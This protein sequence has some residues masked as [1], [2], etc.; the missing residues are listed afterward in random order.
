MKKMII[1]KITSFLGD[2]KRYKDILYNIENA[3]LS[4]RT[5]S[6]IFKNADLEETNYISNK[7]NNKIKILNNVLYIQIDGA[8]ERM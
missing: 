5:I 8:F 1:N 7:N 6:N 3:N 2:E 4:E